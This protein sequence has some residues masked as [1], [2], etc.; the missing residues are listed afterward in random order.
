[1]A[2][3]RTTPLSIL[4]PTIAKIGGS[5]KSA[6]AT[7]RAT[8]DTPAYPNDLRNGSGKKVRERSVT[9]TVRPE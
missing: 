9:K 4:L 5:P 2:D 1:M 6:P 7:A 3:L 8:T